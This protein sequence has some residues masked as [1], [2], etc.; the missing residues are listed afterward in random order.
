MRKKDSMIK[1]LTN[2]L[3]ELKTKKT[4]AGFYNSDYNTLGPLTP[5][6]NTEPESLA[7]FEGKIKSPSMKSKG[8]VMKFAN[9]T[10]QLTHLKQRIHELKAEARTKDQAITELQKTLKFTKLQEYEA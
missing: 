7:Y 10:K 2:E 1:M 5:N 3:Y 9:S 6:F 4:L 8:S